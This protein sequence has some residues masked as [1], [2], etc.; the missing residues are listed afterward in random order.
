MWSRK[1]TKA[2]GLL[3]LPPSLSREPS[4]EDRTTSMEGDDSAGS[5]LHLVYECYGSVEPILDGRAFP[6]RRG[7]PSQ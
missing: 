2:F 6:L 3:L 5:A 4:S 7:I 1:R